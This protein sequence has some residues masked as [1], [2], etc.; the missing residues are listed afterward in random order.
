MDR[1]K[2]SFI[3]FLIENKALRFGSFVTKSGRTSPYF[4]NTGDLF[5]GDLLHTLARYYALTIKN[6]CPDTGCVFGPAYKGIPLAAATVLSLYTDFKINA[7]Y[8]FNRKEKK[9]HAEAGTLVGC[10]PAAADRVV[11]LDDVITAGTSVRE[12][13]DFFRK[14]SRP[15]VNGVVI[16]VD[17]K[18]VG[19]D[20]RHAVT[21][22]K[23]KYQIPVYSIIDIDDIITYL[24][25]QNIPDEKLA[26]RITAYRQKYG[27]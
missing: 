4:I 26:E 2:N 8:S 25:E 22:I 14:T 1:N 11:I 19:Y 10:Q 16:A 3:N 9:D 21:E 20:G 6:N 12:A 5:R 18:E 27:V 17:R 7:A 13:L 23:N 24:K 15:A